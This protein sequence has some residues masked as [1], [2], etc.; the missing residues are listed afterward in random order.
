MELKPGFESGNDSLD[1][2][3]GEDL[4]YGNIGKDFLKGGKNQ[5]VFVL[6]RKTGRDTITDFQDGTDRIDLSGNLDFGD[7]V[8]VQRTKGTL[9][10]VGQEQIG[11]VQGVQKDTLT[12]AD[13]T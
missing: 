11:L 4:L 2:G 5:D 13:F 9:I 10:R 3:D 1:G 6:K 7:L 8:F 12:S